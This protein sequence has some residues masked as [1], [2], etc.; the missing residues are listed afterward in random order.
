[1]KD[2]FNKIKD[3]EKNVKVPYLKRTPKHE[4]TS[5][6]FHLVECL[7]E[8]MMRCGENNYDVHNGYEKEM[9]FHDHFA[10]STPH[11]F[12][13][14]EHELKLS[15]QVRRQLRSNYVTCT[16]TVTLT[17]TLKV[18]YIQIYSK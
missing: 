5:S 11:Y 15:N 16:Y 2:L 1:M 7:R 12:Q 14:P 17:V 4:P 6:Y 13:I 8:C 9:D 18:T 3:F 10:N